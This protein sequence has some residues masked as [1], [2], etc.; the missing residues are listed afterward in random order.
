MVGTIFR[1]YMATL[2]A[3]ASTP[4]RSRPPMAEAIVTFFVCLIVYRGLCAFMNWAPV[5]VVQIT[6]NNHSHND[7]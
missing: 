4:S 3:T 7:A 1:R 2:L 5:P 6:I